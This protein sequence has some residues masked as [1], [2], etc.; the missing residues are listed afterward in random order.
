[1]IALTDSRRRQQTADSSCYYYYYALR[2]FF[3]TP[4][5][6]K[7]QVHLRYN[8]FAEYAGGWCSAVGAWLEV[9]NG[10]SA[11]ALALKPH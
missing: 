6:P 3:G 9:A 10:P 5:L 8:R 2:N 7:A 4:R 11:L 1:M